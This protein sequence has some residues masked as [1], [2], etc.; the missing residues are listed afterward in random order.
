VFCKSL[1]WFKTVK[2]EGCIVSGSNMYFNFD[3]PERYVDDFFQLFSN[4]YRRE[5]IRFLINQDE[6]SH[7]KEF[8]IGEI[9]EYLEDRVDN[10]SDINGL[11]LDLHHSHL[12]KIQDNVEGVTYQ[13]E[14]EKTLK[15]N[16]ESDQ[17][18]KLSKAIHLADEL[19]L[20]HRL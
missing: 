6:D 4:E 10:H 11:K 1:V 17:R 2:I 19:E 7:Q 16:L 14:F 20:S 13:R 12:P 3:N 9:A 18:D 5:T 15:Y 8:N